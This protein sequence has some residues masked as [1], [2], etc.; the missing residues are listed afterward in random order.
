VTPPS[1]QGLIYLYENLNLTASSSFSENVKQQSLG[2]AD[3]LASSEKKSVENI[4]N[5]NRPFVAT[6]T[7]CVFN[8]GGVVAGSR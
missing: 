6:P 1:D 3:G 7:A 8:D 4:G 2:S 5:Y